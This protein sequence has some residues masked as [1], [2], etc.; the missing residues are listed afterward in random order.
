[1][2]PNRETLIR[3]FYDAAKLVYYKQKL[4]RKNQLKPKEIAQCLET[5]FYRYHRDKEFLVMGDLAVNFGRDFPAE[6]ALRY[7]DS[8]VEGTVNDTRG[9]AV[10]ID[11][12]GMDFLYEDHDLNGKY[13]QPRGKRLPW[14]RHTLITSKEIYAGREY[15]HEQYYYVTHYVIPILN[16]E[17]GETSRLH[18][19]FM[20][21][22]RKRKDRTLGFLTAFPI[23]RYNQLLGKLAKL[24]PVFLAT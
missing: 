4:M 6:K 8:N 3:V 15:G 19:Y 16:E 12:L 7:Y 13:I 5:I 14:I 17:K 21:V 1:M 23:D 24:K 11:D 20:V 9:M 22:V 18:S 2:S 10:T